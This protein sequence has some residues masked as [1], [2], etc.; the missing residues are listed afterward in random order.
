V[1]ASD[2]MTDFDG[3]GGRGAAAAAE[4]VDGTRYEGPNRLATTRF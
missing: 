3:A 1:R 2:A 4:A